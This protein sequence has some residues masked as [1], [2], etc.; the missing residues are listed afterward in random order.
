MV[1]KPRWSGTASDRARGAKMKKN[2]SAAFDAKTKARSEALFRELTAS[3]RAVDK[4]HY[5]ALWATVREEFDYPVFVAAPR[6]VGITSTGE[7][8]ETVANEFPQILEAYS[9]FE[10]WINAGAKSEGT[11]G[12]LLPSAA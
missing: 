3:L 5:A 7:T 9:A 12:F 4:T 2:Y 11:P 6:A 8:G 1:S 10:A